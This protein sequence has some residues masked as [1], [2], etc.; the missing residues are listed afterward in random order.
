VKGPG[1]LVIWRR[2]GMQNWSV[3]L[4]KEICL[5]PTGIRTPDRSARSLF[6]IP[7]TPFSPS[8]PAF[9]MKK[10]IDYDPYYVEELVKSYFTIP[11][12]CTVEIASLNNHSLMQ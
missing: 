5:V 8:E 10:L 1:S 2:V 6:T 4:R 7:S 12:S 9:P 3:L 11:D